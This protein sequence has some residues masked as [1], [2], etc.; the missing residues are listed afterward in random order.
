MD[1]T[2][3][4]LSVLLEKFGGGVEYLW[5]KI[6]EYCLIQNWIQCIVF[7]SFVII[8]LSL[9]TISTIGFFKWRS[10]GFDDWHLPVFTIGLLM[11]VVSCCAVLDTVPNILV[12]DVSAA[13]YVAKLVK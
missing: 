3:H 7:S 2:D 8:G 11:F 5:P 4:V 12:P 1:K 6:V 10:Y 13:K 9:L